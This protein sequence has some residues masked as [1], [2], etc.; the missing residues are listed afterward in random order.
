MTAD[1]GL[2]IMTAAY[3]LFSLSQ[4]GEVTEGVYPQSDH[5]LRLLLVGA[6][7][8]I[9]NNQR[10]VGTLVPCVIYSYFGCQKTTEI[11]CDGF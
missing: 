2:S 4:S 5:S 8:P 1:D 9:K 7:I 3:N 10:T 11:T 6:S